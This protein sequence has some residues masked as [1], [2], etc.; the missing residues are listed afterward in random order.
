MD[1]HFISLCHDASEDR[2]TILQYFN[3]SSCLTYSCGSFFKK[4]Q[5]IKKHCVQD[6]EQQRH[7]GHVRP[8]ETTATKH[9]NKNKKGHAVQHTPISDYWPALWSLIS[10]TVG[11][12]TASRNPHSK[13]SPK[14]SWINSRSIASFLRLL[15]RNQLLRRCEEG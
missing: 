2:P 10:V 15:P 13:L 3:I 9:R 11:S 4:L 6:D 8:K 5:K 14:E 12:A 1:E 7:C